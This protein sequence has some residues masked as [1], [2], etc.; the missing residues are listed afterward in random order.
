MDQVIG[1]IDLLWKIPQRRR[2][3]E[4]R[5]VNVQPGFVFPE[6]GRRKAP[7][8]ANDGGD[9]MAGFQQRLDHPQ[10]DV[11]VGSCNEDMHGLTLRALLR[12]PIPNCSRS[13][14]D[15][16]FQNETV[17]GKQNTLCSVC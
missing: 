2:I 9:F 16:R 12:F 10:A 17:Q 7:L 5:F 1:C 11:A 8:V 4:V 14:I 15:S 3:K 6:V 13:A